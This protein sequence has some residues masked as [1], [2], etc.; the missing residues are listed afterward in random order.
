M[1]GLANDKY[2]YLYGTPWFIRVWFYDGR[3]SHVGGMAC[4]VPT[5][6]V[7]YCTG[8]SC[9]TEGEPFGQKHVQVEDILKKLTSNWTEVRFVG[10]R[11]VIISHYTGQ[12][13]SNNKKSV[14]GV[15]HQDAFFCHKFYGFAVFE[16][17]KATEG[18]RIDRFV[19]LH[20]LIRG[21]AFLDSY[22]VAFRHCL[23]PNL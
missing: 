1:H 9:L 17:T 8:Y 23:W 11:Y 21:P 7:Q 3:S 13:T 19:V 4:S 2:I 20:F 16:I 5:Y 10:L 22:R 12:I 14:T 6:I 18:A 15:W